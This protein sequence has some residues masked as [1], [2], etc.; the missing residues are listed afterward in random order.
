MA[1]IET[2]VA[3]LIFSFGVLAAI[4]LQAT[5][6]K[7]VTAAKERLDAS[8]VANEQVGRMWSNPANL[9]PMTDH[10]VSALPDGK[11]T[12]TVIPTTDPDV[13]HVE[14]VVTWRSPGAS[15]DSTHRQAVQISRG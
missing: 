12:V 4:G 6:V 5:S 1:L 8:L 7:A 2:L 11:M 3:V 10:P 13:S 9:I 14:V 15:H